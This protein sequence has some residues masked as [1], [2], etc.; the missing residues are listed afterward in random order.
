MLCLCLRSNFY[1][2]FMRIIGTFS[3][4]E[5]MGEKIMGE[6]KCHQINE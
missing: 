3:K 2:F 5:I 6:K 4:N 1:G